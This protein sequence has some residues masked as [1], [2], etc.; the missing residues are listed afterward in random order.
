MYFVNSGRTCEHAHAGPAG[1]NLT[2]SRKSILKFIRPKKATACIETATPNLD[3]GLGHQLKLLQKIHSLTHWT[4]QPTIPRKHLRDF[5]GLLFRI[6][7]TAMQFLNCQYVMFL[8]ESGR[9][10]K[11]RIH[12][13]EPMLANNPSCMVQRHEMDS[14]ISGTIKYYTLRLCIACFLLLSHAE[15]SPMPTTVAFAVS[16][17]PPDTCHHNCIYTYLINHANADVSLHLWKDCGN[18]TDKCW[19]YQLWPGHWFS[20]RRDDD[21]TTLSEVEWTSFKHTFDDSELTGE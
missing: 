4:I 5:H 6:P 10:W 7:N 8:D 14:V 20:L 3:L 2:W 1:P 17:P 16:A 13:A 21:E 19:R 11:S 18:A 15:S 12:T 9:F